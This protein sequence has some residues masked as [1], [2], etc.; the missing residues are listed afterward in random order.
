MLNYEISVNLKWYLKRIGYSNA[1]IVIKAEN[2][3]ER[4][5]NGMPKNT[6]EFKYF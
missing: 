5:K 3:M 1:Y 6:K 2:D 4:R